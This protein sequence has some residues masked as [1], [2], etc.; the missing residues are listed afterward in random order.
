MK[1]LA[2]MIW[3]AFLDPRIARQAVRD[4]AGNGAAIGAFALSMAPAWLYLLLAGNPY[5]YNS[6]YHAMIQHGDCFD[7]RHGSNDL[8]TGDAFEGPVGGE[9]RRRFIGALAYAQGPPSSVSF[10]FLAYWSLIGLF[11]LI[12]AIREISGAGKAKAIVFIVIGGAVMSRHDAALADSDAHA[13]E[14]L[15]PGTLG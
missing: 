7:R 6:I 1:I 4:K 5:L 11:Q 8:H 13:G 9:A 14:I 10:L 2:W 12:A 3:A 15:I